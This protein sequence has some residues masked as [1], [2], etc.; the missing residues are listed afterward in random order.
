MAINQDAPAATVAVAVVGAIYVEKSWNQVG[1]RRLSCAAGANECD[2]FSSA[3][4][5]VDIAKNL[6]GDAGVIG[7]RK[8]NIFKT[9]ALVESV[10]GDCTGPLLYVVLRVH[11]FEDL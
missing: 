9:H 2:D 5:E 4:I 11:E 10:Q 3:Y 1:E 7:V 6:L 8:S